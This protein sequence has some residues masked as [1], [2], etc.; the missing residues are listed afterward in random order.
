MV[1]HRALWLDLV[2]ELMEVNGLSVAELLEHL[3]RFLLR[4]IKASAFDDALDLS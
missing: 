4:D 1:F 3:G 2:T